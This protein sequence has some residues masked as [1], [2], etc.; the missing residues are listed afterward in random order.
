MT[1]MATRVSYDGFQ[2]DVLVPVVTQIPEFRGKIKCAETD[3]I[4]NWD[5]AT[6]QGANWTEFGKVVEDATIHWPSSFHRPPRNPAKKINS[7]YKATE[8]FLLL[9]GLGPGLFRSFIPR[10]YWRHFCKLVRAVRILSTQRKITAA[11]LLDA[12]YMAIQYV[13]EYE[14]IYYQRRVDRIHFCRPVLHTLIHTPLEAQRVGPG[15][16]TTQFENERAIGDLGK[17]IRQPSNPFGNIAQ[18]AARMARKN[19]LKLIYPE[20]ERIKPLPRG[21][22]DVGNGYTFL[23]PRT[24]KATT[25]SGAAGRCILARLGKDSVEKYGR[26][27]LPNGQ[28]LR[29]MYA[30]S[31]LVKRAPG[32]TRNAKLKINGKTEYGQVEFFFLHITGRNAETGLDIKVPY[33]L[34]TLYSQPIENIW[35]DSY[36]TCWACTKLPD[37]YQVVPITAVEACVS[38]QPMVSMAGDPLNMFQVVEKAGIDD[39]ILSGYSE[40]FEGDEQG[41]AG[42]A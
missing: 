3:D 28:V 31:S 32:I 2:P 36:K 20:L 1:I 21:A 18:I 33:A 12:R 9:F 13:D 37:E 25:I 35:E 17:E 16:Y 23:T 4:K 8:Y 15:T 14:E 39:M 41:G 29:S 38:M 27:S 24:Q 30:E 34:V 26:C 11:Q 40:I 22:Y 5:W 7:K 42:V 6:L 10:R 19:A